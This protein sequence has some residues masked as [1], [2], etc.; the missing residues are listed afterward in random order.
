[1]GKII[2]SYS[3]G[4]SKLKDSTIEEW[5]SVLE[6]LHTE[7]EVSWEEMLDTL[8]W[9]S[10]NIQK[11][12]TPKAYNAKQFV[13]K[14]IQIRAAIVQQEEKNNELLNKI[15]NRPTYGIEEKLEELPIKHKESAQKFNVPN[16][17]RDWC[18]AIAYH[19]IK[20]YM[21]RRHVETEKAQSSNRK[22]AYHAQ[23]FLDI[24]SSV[25]LLLS[26]YKAYMVDAYAKW[27]SGKGDPIS[28]LP[29]DGK[30]WKRFIEDELSKH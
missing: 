2:C 22:V 12:Y 28:W 15:K 1:L 5:A 14:Y 24:F 25:S 19:A 7:N 17:S 26:I 8:K 4:P 16:I 27:Y 9:Y 11:K 6:E 13:N 23:K 10:E 30:M 21:A 3:K 29:P 20:W 18:N